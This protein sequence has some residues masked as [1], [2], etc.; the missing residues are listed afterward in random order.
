MKFVGKILL[1][2]DENSVSYDKLGRSGSSCGNSVV[3]VAALILFLLNSKSFL[4][5][6][7]FGTSQQTEESSRKV[8]SA[9]V[10]DMQSYYGNGVGRR[11]KWR[12]SQVPKSFQECLIQLAEPI[13]LAWLAPVAT[14][15]NRCQPG[16]PYTININIRKTCKIL[17]QSSW[18]I[19]SQK[20]IS[21]YTRISTS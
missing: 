10:N 21:E 6:R 14:S 4:K 17:S 3:K 5:S 1:K 2:F 15:K 8:P 16:K 11:R 12:V 19:H 20:C 13:Y 7:F 9:W 18:H